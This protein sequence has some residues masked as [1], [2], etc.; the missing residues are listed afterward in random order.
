MPVTKGWSLLYRP[1]IDGLRA[2]AVL[3][4]LLFHSKLLYVSGGFVGVDVFFV[5]SGYLI[6]SLILDEGRRGKVSVARF[7]EHRFR[8]ILPAFLL[9]LVSVLIL[10]TIFLLPDDLMNL[11]SSAVAAS[12][13]LANWYFARHV[14]YFQDESGVFPLLHLWSLSVEGQFY[15]VAPLALL[16]LHRYAPR[17]APASIGAACCAA[18]AISVHGTLYWPESVFFSSAA[19][20]F[21]LLLGVRLAYASSITQCR[22]RTM[23]VLPIAGFGMIV[24]AALLYDGDTPFPGIA[25]LLPCGGAALI[26]AFARPKIGL[27]KWLSGSLPVSLGRI[28]YPLYLWHWPLLILSSLYL[29]R[30][31]SAIEIALVY[32]IALLLSIGTHLWLERPI[33]TLW[34]C[35]GTRMRWGWPAAVLLLVTI[36][37]S[38]IWFGKGL[39]G[40][41][42]TEVRALL[43]A[44]DRGPWFTSGCHNLDRADSRFWERCSIGAQG[45]V[46]PTFAVWGDSMA[47]S[48]SPMIS[49]IAKGRYMRGVQFS[50]AGCPPLLDVDVHIRRKSTACK[51]QNEKV[52][53]LL[54]ELKVRHV[55]LVA[56]WGWYSRGRTFKI[57]GWPVALYTGSTNMAQPLERVLLATI[58]LLRK[59]D[60]E[61]TIVGPIPE[62]GWSPP[63]VLAMEAWRRTTLAKE[64]TSSEFLA[65]QSRVMDALHTLE[66]DGQAAVVYPHKYLCDSICRVHERGKVYYADPEHMTMAGLLHIK[67]ALEE[68][69]AHLP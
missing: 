17:Y 51:E 21:E 55:I 38:A 39:P 54:S 43:K 11:A 36:G 57:P 42:P 31:L 66:L 18:A 12:T 59:N 14:D 20:S 32:G 6:A 1:E 67:P 52:L 45:S 41:I 58:R 22:A 69:F 7:Y 8:R 37:A 27:G 2:V 48:L 44:Q 15:A 35:L 16:L 34:P 29:V 9:V 40:R 60:L 33:K 50:H 13:F 19:R 26:I 25:A 63:R 49:E 64:Q 62:V 61:V 65:W 10:G 28:S 23:L 56:N 3:L 30:D 46:H 47:N 24:G 68:L 5:I 4:V 53:S